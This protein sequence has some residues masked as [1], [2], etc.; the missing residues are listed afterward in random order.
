MCLLQNLRCTRILSHLYPED[1]TQHSA[2][3]KAEHSGL[4]KKKKTFPKKNPMLW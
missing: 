4:K 1:E 3:F 2:D